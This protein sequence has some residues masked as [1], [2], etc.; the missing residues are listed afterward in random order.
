LRLKQ[1]VTSRNANDFDFGDEVTIDED[2]MGTDQAK[3]DA[4]QVKAMVKDDPKYR[5]ILKK[6]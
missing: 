4:A 1:A 3:A 2:D 6:D 5:S